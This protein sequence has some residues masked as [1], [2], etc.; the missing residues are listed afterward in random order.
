MSATFQ[1]LIIGGSV[2]GLAAAFALRR[3]AGADVRVYE[4]S[5]GLMAARGAGVVMQPEVAA[6]LAQCGVSE[7]SVS[8]RLEARTMLTR[9][10]DAQLHRAPQTMTAW[11]T[12]YK[13]LR[14]FLADICYRQDSE[15]IDL[16]EESGRVTARFA[17][18]YRAE[19]DWLVG[20]DGVNSQCRRQLLGNAETRYAGYVAWRGLEDENQLPPDLV[21]TLRDRFTLFHTPGMQFLCYLV[22]GADGAI[23]PGQRRVNW[24]W[25]V[26]TDARDLDDL[27]LGESGRR[28]ASFLPKGEVRP[29]IAAR[30][31]A[32]ADASLP[33]QLARLLRSSQLFLQPVQDVADAPRVH[34]RVA[35]LGDAAGTVRPH[36]AAGTA[37][38]FGDA[39][40]LAQALTGW[41]ADAP[42]PAAALD[43]WDRSRR[44]DQRFTAARGLQIAA[45]SA[46]GV[47]GAPVPWQTVFNPNQEDAPS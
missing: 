24:V 35:L 45:A 3:V 46:L 15:L 26:N 39:R 37:K 19:G 1:A 2:G 4:R 31:E 5:R 6:L 32:L 14:G 29:A 33:P 43:D 34:G 16:S 25:Y 47:A 30:V 21:A 20:A 23:A 27:L 10:G 13:T 12:L 11:D 7:A 9:S 38:A 44:D 17:D 8:V 42:L 22:P 28:Y 18:D 41:S 40:T 36:T